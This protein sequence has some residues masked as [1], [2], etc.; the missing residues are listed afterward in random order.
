MCH[1]M[2]SDCCRLSQCPGSKAIAMH[3]FFW[4]TLY[5]LTQNLV[6]EFCMILF[7]LVF[8]GFYVK[9]KLKFKSIWKSDMHLLCSDFISARGLLGHSDLF[10]E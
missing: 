8:S 4:D 1:E 5:I 10:P 3:N 2:L 9:L 6:W 7:P